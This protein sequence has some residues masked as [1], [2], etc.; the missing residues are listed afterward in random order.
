MRKNVEKLK[1][2]TPD[3]NEYSTRLNA[4]EASEDL[5]SKLLGE[6]KGIDLRRYPDPDSTLLRKAVSSYTGAPVENIICGNGSDEIIR[7]ILDVSAGRGDKV[8]VH[9]PTFSEYSIM[10]TINEAD[11]IKVPSSEEFE[12]DIDGIIK[13]ANE[14]DAKL[15]FLCT[16]NNPTGGVISRG[17]VLR[18]VDETES[19][20]VCDEAYYEFGRSTNIL[21]AVSRPRLIVMRTLSKAFALAGARVGYAVGSLEMI[22]N[23]NKVRMP[24]N[25]NSISQLL[26]LKAL[27]NEQIMEI[28]TMVTIAQRDEMASK[29]GKIDGIKVYDSCANFLLIK[30]RYSQKISERFKEESI[31]VRTFSDPLLELCMR[32]SIGT[33]K[34]NEK[35]CTIIEEVCSDG[36]N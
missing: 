13:A 33:Q 16:P 10:S 14:N 7:M 31:G 19:V 4:N 35:I 3:K 32:I 30:T 8:I 24:Y 12:V 17:G 23:L 25:L 11:V 28:N 22:G 26:A 9:T 5:Y 18:V 34:E 20:V 1:A 27:E 15:I 2:Y 36:G 6:L 21:D 29:L